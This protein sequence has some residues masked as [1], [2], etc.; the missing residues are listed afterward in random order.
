M[1][2]LLLVQGIVLGNAA[3]ATSA[4][5]CTGNSATATKLATARKI[6]GTNFDGS[7]DITTAKWGTARTLALSGAVSGSASVDGSGNV[8]ISTTQANIATLTGTISMNDNGIGS[9]SVAFP[10]G[11]NKDNCVVLSVM[12]KYGSSFK[13]WVNGMLTNTGGIVNDYIVTLGKV[14]GTDNNKIYI[15]FQGESAFDSVPYKIV[16]MKV[17]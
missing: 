9:T 2:L 8:T 6:N 4:G 5:K 15:Q 11:F 1:L 13:T 3:T 16:L 10:S 12:Y 14:D 7:A 17:S